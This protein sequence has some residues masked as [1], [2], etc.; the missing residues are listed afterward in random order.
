MRK[1][2]ILLSLIIL[3]AFAFSQSTFKNVSLTLGG[4][5][6]VPFSDNA[7]S[8]Y[9]NTTTLYK[10]NDCWNNGFNLTAGFE[11]AFL[12]ELTGHLKV[13]YSSFSIN[14]SMVLKQLHLPSGTYVQDAE[15]NTVAAYV[16]ARYRFPYEP[17]EKV[18]PYVTASAGIMNLASDKIYVLI[19][20]NS[21][22]VAS[23]KNSNVACGTAAVGVDIIGGEN[24]A[25][26]IQVGVDVANTD[27]GTL[28]YIP[29]TV[30]F[31]GT[32]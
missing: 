20:A 23:F 10:F 14:K 32:F 19:D 18:Y 11:Y 4:G 2:V 27:G 12:P 30:G 29:L 15:F 7:M 9:F 3:P 21:N 31:R 16:G 1:L 5:L 24:S 8:K 26:F 13:S 6:S 28:Y 25:M 22:Y 17:I